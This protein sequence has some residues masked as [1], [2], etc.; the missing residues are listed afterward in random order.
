MCKVCDLAPSVWGA[1]HSSIG[2]NKEGLKANCFFYKLE[3]A[4]AAFKYIVSIDHSH[5]KVDP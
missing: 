5:G 3:A 1:K 2:W 4:L